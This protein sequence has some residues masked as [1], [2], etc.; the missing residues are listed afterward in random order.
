MKKKT[1]KKLYSIVG[2]VL[3]VLAGITIAYAALSATLNVTVN[4]LTMTSVGLD[5]HFK[6][7]SVTA[8]KANTNN[9]S[10]T[11]IVCGTATSSGSE[12]TV[13][14]TTLDLPGDKCTYTLTVENTGALPVKLTG[15]AKKGSES[16]CGTISGASYTCGN[17]TYKLT[18][19]AA[20]TTA[21][22]TSSA[23]TL[24]ASTGTQT[25]YLVVMHKDHDA[26]G[27]VSSA[28]SYSNMGFSLTY[29]Q[30]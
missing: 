28:T 24:A 15:I 23:P 8:T 29:T 18:T 2:A 12:V 7:E 9:G 14:D 16:A 27:L 11:D 6:T 26:S 20:G 4:K 22:S 19:D 25:I 10:T 17:I 3:L 30:Q 5:V 1:K 13:A 21:L